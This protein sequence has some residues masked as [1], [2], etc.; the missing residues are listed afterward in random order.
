MTKNRHHTETDNVQAPA[1]SAAEQ[2]NLEPSPAGQSDPAAQAKISTTAGQRGT[3]GDLVGGLAGLP[4]VAA[5]E[6]IRSN[7]QAGYYATV[8]AAQLVADLEA[9]TFEDAEHT[10]ARDKLIEQARAGSFSAAG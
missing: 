2:A 8:P 6:G 7:A 1:G 10:A 9:V 5:L 3:R 4:Q